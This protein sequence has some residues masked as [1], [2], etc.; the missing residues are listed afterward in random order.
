MPIP[1]NS[2]LLIIIDDTTIFGE[3]NI[4]CHRSYR[5]AK[6]LLFVPTAQL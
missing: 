1:E 3:E 6:P 5:S 4:G 2:E